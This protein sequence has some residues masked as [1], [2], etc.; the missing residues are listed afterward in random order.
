MQPSLPLLCVSLNV[1]AQANGRQLGH[2]CGLCPDPLFLLKPRFEVAIFRCST[3]MEAARVEQLEDNVAMLLSVIK[4]R[5][6]RHLTC[7]LASFGA[8][9]VN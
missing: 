6:E 8:N 5:Y 4:V 9:H 2:V 7:L 3:R 1:Q